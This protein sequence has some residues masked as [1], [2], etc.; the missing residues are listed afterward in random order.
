TMAPGRY[1]EP[2]SYIV[3]VAGNLG[4]LAIG[5][6]VSAYPLALAMAVDALLFLVA[7]LMQNAVQY[8]NQRDQ[9]MLS[10][11]NQE[12]ARRHAAAEAT[13]RAAHN[14][15]NDAM[16]SLPIAISLWDAEDKLVMCNETYARH[17]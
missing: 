1:Y 17:L 7:L 2:R 13:A 9:V 5:A 8:R 11:A 3:F 15:L 16:E 6:L 4:P 12:L 14:A 10:L